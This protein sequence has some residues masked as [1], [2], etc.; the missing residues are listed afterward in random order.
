[1]RLG[2]GPRSFI[3]TASSPL[4]CFT[5]AWRRATSVWVRVRAR[6][7]VRVRARVR[8]RVRARVR[9]RIRVEVRVR[10]R[11]EVRVRVRATQLHHL[12]QL[13]HLRTQRHHLRLG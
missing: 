2:L 1:L 12:T 8:V 7:R 11:V 9:V 6:V 10:N 13:L 5:S 3:T 4:S